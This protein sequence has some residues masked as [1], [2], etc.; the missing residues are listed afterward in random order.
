MTTTCSNMSYADVTSPLKASCSM[1]PPDEGGPST[2]FPNVKQDRIDLDKLIADFEHLND[3]I[4]AIHAKFSSNATI[5]DSIES[6]ING[7]SLKI[8]RIQDSIIHYDAS[9][10]HN[11]HS[12]EAAQ[13]NEHII[14]VFDTTIKTT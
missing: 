4:Q 14:K 10:D 1:V 11:E 7:T 2:L 12:L 3:E 8:N 5:L 9:F 6:K 13:E